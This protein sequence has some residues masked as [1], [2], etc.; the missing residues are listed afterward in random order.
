MKRPMT[1]LAA[2][3]LSGILIG[4]PTA[5]AGIYFLC[6]Y[7][8]LILFFLYFLWKYPTILNPYVTEK[9][10][11][12]MTWFL[13]LIPVLFLGG[14]CRQKAY[15]CQVQK[16]GTPWY[17]LEEQEETMVF[18]VGCVFEKTEGDTVSF[19]LSDC[20][21][22]GYEE[23]SKKEETKEESAALEKAGDCMVTI[24]EGSNRFPECKIGN[25]IRVYGRFYLYEEAGNPGQ[26]DAASYYQEKG[27]Y[28]FIKA[29]RIDVVS[30]KTNAVADTCF[31]LRQKM[32]QVLE[33]LYPEEKA[34]V[35]AA[36]LLGD[37]DLLPETIKKLYQQNGI[38]HIL[39]ISGLHISILC[40]GL[41]RLLRRM[42]L[43]TF[44]AAGISGIFLIFYVWFTGAGVSS[45]RAGV[46]FGVWLLGKLLRRNY[47]L[48]SSLSFAAVLVTALRPQEV[49]NAGFLLSF[50]S[51]L[52]VALAQELHME[53]LTG[54][55]IQLVTAP[56]SVFYYYEA[57]PYSVI[58]NLLILP[59]A[60]YVL[61]GGLCSVLTGLFFMEGAKILAGGTYLLLSL[62]EQIG[63]LTQKL[64]YSF[65]LVGRPGGLRMAGYYLALLFFLHVAKKREEKRLF[66]LSASAVIGTVILMAPKPKTLE[67]TFLD[68]SQGDGIY[69]QTEGREVFLFDGGSTDAGSVGKYRIA[70]FLKEKGI[71]VVDTVVVSHM[72][73]DHYSGIE[74]L[75]REMPVYCGEKAYIRNYTGAVGIERLVLP[76]VKQPSEEYLALAEL[77]REKQVEV[78]FISA[79]EDLYREQELLLTC[80][81]P[82]E[83][84]TSENDTSLVFL[85]QTEKMAVWLMG[86]AGTKAEEEIAER[87]AD[88]VKRQKGKHCILKV[89]HHGSKTSS[90]E[91]FLSLIQPDTA[92]ISCGYKN[93]Y[94]HPHTDVLK[95]LESCGAQIFR[96]DVQGAVTVRNG[97]WTVKKKKNGK[98]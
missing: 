26:F 85:L 2:A 88:E 24:P 48:L 39:A 81:S 91:A 79:G 31:E 77:C 72:D 74:E 54:G 18:A 33:E 21:I 12:A 32:R 73:S 87:F 62:Y 36:M 38:V 17:L 45:L 9:K 35:L 70:P 8:V 15:E 56:I 20:R 40:M 80:L 52:G 43:P 19:R 86:D 13:I 6:S 7:A 5:A 68:V 49:N 90:G 97:V 63:R 95:R 92:V 71:A 69:L 42:T 93:R 96:T 23:K 16:S 65:V 89:G 25:Q 98:F 14:M 58:L 76:L 44:A 78:L 4:W 28:A 53:N 82:W 37:K 66:Y 75:L 27:I 83:A 3:W 57:A 55:I 59:T 11:G 47:D 30:E 94:G 41:F 51:V 46:M 61:C 22:C 29:V 34:G 64:P 10:Y 84:K 67:L 60:P 1:V 50:F